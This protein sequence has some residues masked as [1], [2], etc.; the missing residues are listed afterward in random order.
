M[1]NP[2][3]SSLIRRRPVYSARQ[4]VLQS[5]LEFALYSL[6]LVYLFLVYSMI[7]LRLTIVLQVQMAPKSDIIYSRGKSKSVA[8]SGTPILVARVT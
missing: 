4:R 2:I 7:A 3:D 1:T 6:F 8:Q 5:E